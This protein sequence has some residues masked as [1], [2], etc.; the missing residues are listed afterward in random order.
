VNELGVGLHS[1]GFTEGV[2]F[3][4]GLWMGAQLL[5]IACGLIPQ[6]LWISHLVREGQ[7]EPSLAKS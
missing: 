2:L 6:R 4:L 3:F 5:L 1:Y 7:P